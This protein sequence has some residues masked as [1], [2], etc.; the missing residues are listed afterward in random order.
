MKLNLK[1]RVRLCIDRIRQR[2]ADRPG[3]TSFAWL[4]ADRGVRMA[5][6]LLVGGWTARYL[7][8]ANFGLLNYAMA[9]VAIFASM[10]PLGM[11]GLAVR[12]IIQAPQSAGDWLG[13]IIGFRAI[14]ATLCAGLALA[15]ITILRPGESNSL[16]IVG[17]LA[18]GLVGQS[19]ESGELIFQAK[20]I[21]HRLILPRLALFLLLTAL[22]IAAIMAGMSLLWFAVLTAFEQL[23]SGSITWIMA[24]HALG[25]TGPLRFIAARGWHLIRLSWPLAVSALA[26][27]LYLK[28]SQL[29]LSRMLDDEALGIY[30]AAIRFSEAAGFLPVALATSLL[31][32][33]MRKHTLGPHEYAQAILRYFR[34]SV[35]LAYALCT[36]L[37]LVAPW[38]IHRLFG[39]DYSA[40]VP[41]MIIHV[42][43]LV[44]VF[45][46][47]ARGQH[48]V[49]KRQTGHSL[50]FN[51][52]G[53]AISIG[54]NLALIPRWGAIGAATA[55]V[56]SYALANVLASFI[57]PETRQI[58]KLQLIALL[59]PWNAFTKR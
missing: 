31:P 53:L 44:F 3:A 45:L 48:L 55:T 33:L 6:A 26:V 30:S 12:E 17:L 56:L 29:L 1:N 15:S 9:L 25:T 2:S 8:T 14:A 28:L 23:V 13:T 10:A 58:G 42:W 5:V 27:M 59:T 54:L 4:V 37:C 34:I 51:L 21:L 11:E 35:A 19:L 20:G 50:T 49:T 38:L 47:V 43:T 7:G 40:S 41:V 39:R 18:L 52:L 46:G 32:S 36:A 22:K 57:F 24:R 16:A